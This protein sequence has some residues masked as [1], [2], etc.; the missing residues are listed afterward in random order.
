MS[1]EPRAYTRRV[2][3]QRGATLASTA[4]T[5]PWFVQNAAAGVMPTTNMISSIPGIPDD[6]VMVIS[7]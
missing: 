5:I 4:A 1:P 7:Q 2:F 3:L 6:R